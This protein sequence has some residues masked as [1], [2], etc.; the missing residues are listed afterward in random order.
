MTVLILPGGT[1]VAEMAL[2]ATDSLPEECPDQKAIATLAE[3]GVLLRFPTGSDGGFLLSAYIDQPI[4]EEVLRFCD[5]DDAV[6]S[7]MTFASGNLAFGGVE[8]AW[9][10]GKPNPN[11]RSDAVIPPGQYSVVAYRTNIPDEEFET[12]RNHALSKDDRRYLAI[13]NFVFPIGLI[14]I[15]IAGALQLYLPAVTILIALVGW[16]QWF[17]QRPTYLSLL[18]KERQAQVQF[19]SIV[20]ELKLNRTD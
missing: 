2:F 10:T 17:R 5:L 7:D 20:V 8:S 4:P 19:P 3:A 11:I 15:V 13:P 6:R 9:R 1:D 12:A 14:A 16:W 18:T